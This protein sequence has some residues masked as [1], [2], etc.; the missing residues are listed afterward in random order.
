MKVDLDKCIDIF[1][2]LHLY[3]QKSSKEGFYR[4]YSYQPDY[5]SVKG[6]YARRNCE[7]VAR[8]FDLS[9][10]GNLEWCPVFVSRYPEFAHIKCVREEDKSYSLTLAPQENRT[11]A[12]SLLEA[13]HSIKPVKRVRENIVVHETHADLGH[14]PV[15]HYVNSYRPIANDFGFAKSRSYNTSR[16][17]RRAQNADD[18]QAS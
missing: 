17:G 4:I 16:K 10:H 3:A 8:I 11:L 13:I 12:Q 9:G 14:I 1:N 18:Q 15:E 5:D 6:V 2:S 7:L